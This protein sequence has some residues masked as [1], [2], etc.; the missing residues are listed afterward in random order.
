MEEPGEMSPGFFRLYHPL[1]HTLTIVIPAKRSASR[2]RGGT[3]LSRIQEPAPPQALL[4]D[5]LILNS[6]K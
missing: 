4:P 1:T 3:G 6:A 5:Q 2:D